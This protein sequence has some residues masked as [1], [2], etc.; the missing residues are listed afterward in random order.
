MSIK[1]TIWNEGRH[2]QVH[3]AV[4]DIYPDRIDGA[5]A[6][7][8]AH[9]DFDIRRGTLDDPGEG[10]PQ[11]LLEDT[12]VLLWWGHM[13]H[14]DVSDGLIDRVQQGLLQILICLMSCIVDCG[15]CCSHLLVWN[16]ADICVIW[17]SDMKKFGKNMKMSAGKREDDMVFIP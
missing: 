10:L 14:D 6:K 5:I 3:K 2:E 15:R 12:D 13:A 16:L 17:R 7:G 11:S 9:A 1:V 4:S 8:I